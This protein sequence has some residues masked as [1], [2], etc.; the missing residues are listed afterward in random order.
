MSHG[1][2]GSDIL[3]PAFSN[4]VEPIE[5]FCESLQYNYDYLNFALLGHTF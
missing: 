2:F 1:K 3:H 5:N 4:I